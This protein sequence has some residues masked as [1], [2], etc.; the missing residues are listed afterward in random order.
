M[1]VPVF[2]PPVGPSF[3]NTKVDTDARTLTAALG[4]GYQQ[5]T[6]DGINTIRDTWTAQWDGCPTTD[7][8]AII[9]FFVLMGGWQVFEWTA[10]GET[11]PKLWRCAKW[12]KQPTGPA[13]WSVTAT[14]IQ[15]FDTVSLT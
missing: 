4:D 1:A 14:I 9:G 8:Q 5:V 12:G 10:P 15:Q 3:Q 11:T 13:T 2:N 7:M 6:A